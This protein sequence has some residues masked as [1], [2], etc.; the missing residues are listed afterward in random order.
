MQ[1]A[2]LYK[3]VNLCLIVGLIITQEPL[4]RFPF[5][6]DWGTQVTHWN[7]LSLVLGFGIEKVNFNSENLV[8]R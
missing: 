1:Y 3:V 2:Y 4:D 5:N 8:S 6:F 7:V